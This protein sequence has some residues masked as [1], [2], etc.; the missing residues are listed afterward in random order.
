MGLLFQLF[1]EFFKTGLFAIGGGL[2]TLPFLYEMQ[3][4]TGWFTVEDITNMIAV[5]EATPGPLGVNMASYVGYL[6]DGAGGSLA[7][8]LGLVAPSVLCV[9]LVFRFLKRFQ[10][11]K[12]V[13]HIMQGLRAASVA[14]ITAAGL[15]VAQ[16]AFMGQ[17]KL[18]WIN[19]ALA[20][21]LFAVTKLWKK[22]SPILLILLSGLAGYLLKL[23]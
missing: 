5:S 4:G 17:G 11:N 16:V 15:G 13:Q 7:A 2:A 10:E 9:L 19:L 8:T 12:T 1:W 3:K 6:T 22:H 21:A 20:A 23:S 14:M 18:D